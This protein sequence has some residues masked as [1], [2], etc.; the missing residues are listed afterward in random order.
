VGAG[1]LNRALRIGWIGAA[2]AGLLSGAI[3]LVVAIRPELWVGLYSADPAVLATGAAYLRIVGAVY[4][5]Q[6]V[7]LSLYFASQGAGTVL[8]PL[9]AGVL[10]MLVTAGGA[11]VAVLMLD[12]GLP[13]IFVLTA[14]GMALFGAVTALSILL[15][16]WRRVR[17]WEGLHAYFHDPYARRRGRRPVTDPFV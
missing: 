7:G 4:L 12:M 6:G 1:N 11:A 10:R 3:G 17:A 16:A 15:G 2:A 13:S 9:A 5:F 8:W 14:A